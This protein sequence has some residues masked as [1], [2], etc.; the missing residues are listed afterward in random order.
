MVS[1]ASASAPRADSTAIW[2]AVLSG[3]ERRGCSYTP[4][5]AISP[6]RLTGD[7]Q[8]LGYR[9]LEELRDQAVH[10]V[11]LL[12]VRDVPALGDPL[13]ARPPD[14]TGEPLPRGRRADPILGAMEHEDGHSQG[15]ERLAQIGGAGGGD[16]PEADLRIRLRE[17]APEGPHRVQVRLRAEVRRVELLTEASLDDLSELDQLVLGELPAHRRA[18]RHDAP[19]RRRTCDRGRK[20]DVAAVAVADEDRGRG[21]DAVEEGEHR[22]DRRADVRRRVEPRR[23]PVRW[24]VDRDRAVLAAEVSELLRP[25]RGAAALPGQEDDRRP[26]IEGRREVRQRGRAARG[27]GVPALAA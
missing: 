17:L 20:R 2:Y 5:T 10:R 11:R 13:E 23:P 7:L 8:R 6:R 16:V 4:T 19:D 15:I 1:P 21:R 27:V 25:H 9:A 18:D 22:I 14:R 24:K 3:A 12:D 26:A